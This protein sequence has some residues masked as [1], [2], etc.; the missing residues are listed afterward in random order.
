MPQ[1]QSNRSTG[2][3]GQATKKITFLQLPLSSP[4]FVKTMRIRR[5]GSD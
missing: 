2:L 5:S 3:N 4:T 1:N